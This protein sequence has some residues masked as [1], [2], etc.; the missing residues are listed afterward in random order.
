MYVV[1]KRVFDFIFAL[2]LIIVLMPVFVLIIILLL[3][4][5]REEVF[6]LQKRIGLNNTYFNI[7][8]FSSMLKGALFMPGGAITLRNDPRVT[9]IGKLLRITKL[10]ELPQLFNVLLGNMSFVGPRPIMDD[11][12]ALYSIDAQSVLYKSKPGITG[13]S[14]LVF[15]DEELL[16]TNSGIEPYLFYKEY[17]FP[18]K[19]KLEIWYYE[20]KSFVIDL[21]IL[22]FTGIKIIAPKSKLE[23][24]IFK[25]LPKND[26]IKL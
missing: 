10:N 5:N 16:V 9:K 24:K 3:I 21:I 8:K 14:S 11:G 6:Y 26:L 4:F 19:S 2:I 15:R 22:F 20:N 13:I 23:F 12:F 7:F 1:N 17:V 25:S 18:Y